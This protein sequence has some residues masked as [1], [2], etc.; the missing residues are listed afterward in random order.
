MNNIYIKKLIIFMCL[1]INT[2]FF[3]TSCKYSDTINYK[4]EQLNE[5]F[6]I[7]YDR[8]NAENFYE[9][10]QLMSTYYSDELKDS[11]SRIVD[12][13]NND[14]TYNII[15]DN[16]I[17]SEILYQNINS[18]KDNK[19]HAFLIVKYDTKDDN[20]SFCVEYDFD[21]LYE[22]DYIQAIYML[23]DNYIVVGNSNIQINN[24]ELIIYD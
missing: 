17:T 16:E 7:R 5:Y 14:E 2:L 19:F 13:S 11:G 6:N 1:I 8:L 24:G 10:N 9:R 15:K 4:I 22:E 23:S 3:I 21:I 20:N 18:E 12:K